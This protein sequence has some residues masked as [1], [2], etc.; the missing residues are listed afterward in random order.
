MKAHICIGGP[1]DGKFAISKDFEDAPRHWEYP[2]GE[3]PR[4]GPNGNGREVIDGPAGMYN[5]LRDDYV[6]YNISVRSSW[7]PKNAPSMVWLHKDLLKPSK[8]PRER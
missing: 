5:H 4:F 8:S 6:Q 7:V 1:L 2:E 3:S